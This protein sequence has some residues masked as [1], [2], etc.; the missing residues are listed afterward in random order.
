MPELSTKR[1]PPPLQILYIVYSS[2]NWYQNWGPL[3][4]LILARVCTCTTSWWWT[5]SWTTRPTTTG[6]TWCWAGWR[7]WPPPSPGP[8]SPPPTW[9]TGQHTQRSTCLEWLLFVLARYCSVRLSVAVSLLFPVP[10]VIRFMMM[11]LSKY[12]KFIYFYIQLLLSS[13]YLLFLR[14]FIGSSCSDW[15]LAKVFNLMK[16]LS[17]VSK[18]KFRQKE[19]L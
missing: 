15:W 1:T 14:S 12:L 17:M 2:Q 11:V 4:Y 7:P 6:C 13:Y 16:Y 19:H 9:T 18:S 5:S 3:F 8:R 10:G